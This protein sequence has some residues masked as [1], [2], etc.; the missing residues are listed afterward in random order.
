MHH[1]MAASSTNLRS[2]LH[3]YAYAYAGCSGDK[4]NLWC[5]RWWCWD[6]TAQTSSQIHWWRAVRASQHGKLLYKLYLMH[7]ATQYNPQLACVSKSLMHSCM[8]VSCTNMPEAQPDCCFAYN[9]IVGMLVVH[10]TK[11]LCDDAGSDEGTSQP[12]HRES[13]LVHLQCS[14]VAMKFCLFDNLK[15]VL[16]WPHW[17][18]TDRHHSHFQQR[19]VSIPIHCE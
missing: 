10:V 17:S 3:T 8:A 5:C 18:K 12:R 6:F 11:H 7:L 15:T 14:Y 9:A 4:A 2:V 19:S 1:C 13:I 16:S